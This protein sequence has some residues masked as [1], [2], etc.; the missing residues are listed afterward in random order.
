LLRGAATTNAG[1]SIFA[2]SIKRL[3]CC[4][5]TQNAT[6]M[7]DQ[8]VSLR[9]YWTS[10]RLPFKFLNEIYHVCM[11]EAEKSHLP[12][13]VFTVEEIAAILKISQ[14]S[15]YRLIERKRLHALKALRHHRITKKSLDAFLAGGVCE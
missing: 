6:G 3:V 4:G 9:F 8:N 12:Q 11:F 10:N 15:V 5:A 7:A 14:K 13:M 2:G 1:F